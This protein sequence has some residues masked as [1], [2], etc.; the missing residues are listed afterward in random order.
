MANSILVNDNLKSFVKKL[1]IS[2]DKKD[3][4]LLKIPKLDK[5]ERL[6]LLDVLSEMYLSTLE[7]KKVIEKIKADWDKK[8]S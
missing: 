2:Q 6:K 4:L 5:E 7:E 8:I 3:A 1:D